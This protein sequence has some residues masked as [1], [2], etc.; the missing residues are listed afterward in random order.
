MGLR[1]RN[2]TRIRE[3]GFNRAPSDRSQHIRQNMLTAFNKIAYMAYG[4]IRKLSPE[5]LSHLLI[6]EERDLSDVHFSETLGGNILITI[7]I[8]CGVIAFLWLGTFF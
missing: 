1:D 8:L 6:K 2:T 7:M 5:N 3:P 4:F